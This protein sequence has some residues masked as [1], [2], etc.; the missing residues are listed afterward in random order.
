MQ[1]DRLLD[2]VGK[3]GKLL[4]ESGAEIYRV[5]ETMLHLARS[6]E[7][8]QEAQSYVSATGVMLSIK[9]DD[10]IATKIF[11]VSGSKVN[12]DRIAAINNLSREASKKALTLDELDQKL[13]AIEFMKEYPLWVI[14]IASGFGA[15][16]FC[17]FFR[18]N[19]KEIMITFIIGVLVA[20]AMQILK[21]LELNSFFVNAISAGLLTFLSQVSTQLVAFVSKDI[22]IISTIMLLVPGLAITNAIRDMFHSDYVSG[23]ARA[24]EA[25]LC[26]IAIA[27]GVGLVLS[28]SMG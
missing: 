1:Q 3:A 6:F 5:E 4:I 7:E 20:A 25:F 15:A 9:V 28:F 21:K 12:L 10:Q 26:A 24:M 18:G 13:N 23:S 27:S 22:I 19:V 16:G 14:L 17:G 2:L 11:R 8:V